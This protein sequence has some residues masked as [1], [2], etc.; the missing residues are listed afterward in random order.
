MVNRKTGICARAMR[1]PREIV[2]RPR[3]VAPDE[4]R[5]STGASAHMSVPGQS[6]RCGKVATRPLLHRE[7]DLLPMIHLACSMSEPGRRQT[8]H[9]EH[10]RERGAT[11]H[12]GTTPSF[13]GAAIRFCYRVTLT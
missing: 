4:R 7:A 12:L 11:I 1:Y 2:G 10:G 5:A 3:A 8:E 9:L 6:R 13:R